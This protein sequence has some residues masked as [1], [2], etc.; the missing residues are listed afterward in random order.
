[1]EKANKVLKV[2]DKHLKHI[3]LS[4]AINSVKMEKYVYDLIERDIENK[5]DAK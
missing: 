2:C 3:K 4:S 1:M 5:R